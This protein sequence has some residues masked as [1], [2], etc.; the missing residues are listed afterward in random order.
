MWS[1]TTSSLLPEVL[2]F[3]VVLCCMAIHRIIMNKRG[4]WSTIMVALSRN[5]R[6]GIYSKRRNIEAI[7]E[8]VKGKYFS[9]VK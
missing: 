7:Y 9:Q 2:S 1:T 4:Y 5:H 6:K 3:L 8:C